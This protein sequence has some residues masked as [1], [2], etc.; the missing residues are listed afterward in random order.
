M[1]VSTGSVT[2][3]TE[4]FSAAGI[5]DA[6]VNEGDVYFNTA[7]NLIRLTK[8]V[9]GTGAW[10]SGGN[11]NQ[12]SICIIWLLVHNCSLNDSRRTYRNST[13]LMLQ[14]IYD[15]S[16][17]TSSPTINTARNNEAGAGS[18]TTH[19]RFNLWR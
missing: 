11:M 15:G 7:T 6:I 18:G 17:W 5:T 1:E 3:A 16:T 9:F 2:A 13:A 10:A 4:E 14:T 12:A 19:C 8:K